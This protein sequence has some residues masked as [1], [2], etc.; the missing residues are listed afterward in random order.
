MQTH[1]VPEIVF[2][3]K[4]FLLKIKGE[5]KECAVQATCFERNTLFAQ[6]KERVRRFR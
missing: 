2:A 6:H 5:I 3:L 4:N 1:H